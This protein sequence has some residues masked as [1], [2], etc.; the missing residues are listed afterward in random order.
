MREDF[1]TL[2]I[3]GLVALV[4]LLAFTTGWYAVENQ[5]QK[6]KTEAALR[7]AT[8][9]KIDPKTNQDRVINFFQSRTTI[10]KAFSTIIWSKAGNKA[11]QDEMFSYLGATTNSQKQI[12]IDALFKQGYKRSV[13]TCYNMAGKDWSLGFCVEKPYPQEQKS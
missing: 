4:G 11:E 5:T 10:K 1:K 3:V 12:V 9:V 7:R 8:I 2:T 6:D 13:S